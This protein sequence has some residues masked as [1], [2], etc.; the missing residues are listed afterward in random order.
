M[1]HRSSAIN[2]LTKHVKASRAWNLTCPLL[3]R[4]IQATPLWRDAVLQFA[5]TLHLMKSIIDGVHMS[6]CILVNNC[7]SRSPGF[8]FTSN[9]K[10]ASSSASCKIL[11]GDSYFAA[12]RMALRFFHILQSIHGM[13]LTTDVAGVG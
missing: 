10:C 4:A 9:R 3:S 1:M 2:L 13:V 8:L 6:L 5:W 11:D 12:N 7:P